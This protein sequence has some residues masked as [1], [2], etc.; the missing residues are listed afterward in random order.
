MP[1]TKTT[2][3][4]TRKHSN[5]GVRCGDHNV[6]SSATQQENY[7]LQKHFFHFHIHYIF[8]IIYYIFSKLYQDLENVGPFLL[9]KGKLIRIYDISMT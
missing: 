3:I 1:K 6:I 9:H 7:I 8:Y 2:N 4:K 5:F